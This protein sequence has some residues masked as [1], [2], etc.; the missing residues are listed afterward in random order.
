[1]REVYFGFRPYPASGFWL[2]ASGHIRLPAS[3]FRLP[4][5]GFRLS[6]T[7]GF[8]LPASGFRPGQAGGLCSFYLA[9]LRVCAPREDQ[10]KRESHGDRHDHADGPPALTPYDVPALFVEIKVVRLRLSNDRALPQSSQN[11]PSLD[12]ELGERARV[13]LVDRT[14][15]THTSDHAAFS[16]ED[17]SND[18][19]HKPRRVTRLRAFGRL[20]ASASRLPAVCGSRL[21]AP[22]FRRCAGQGRSGASLSNASMRAV[23]LA[24]MCSDRSERDIEVERARK[25]SLWDSRIR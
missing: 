15:R 22:G 12:P 11:H 4:A 24:A 6:A 16:G 20:P 25:P 17:D 23:R 1:M 3:G 18:V 10:R 2:P 9:R 8:R 14:C 21:P 5:F 19:I 13:A 7:F